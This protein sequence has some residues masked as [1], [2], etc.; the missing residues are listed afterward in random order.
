MHCSKYCIFMGFLVV[1]TWLPLRFVCP[2]ACLCWEG[3]VAD[4]TVATGYETRLGPCLSKHA[5]SVTCNTDPSGQEI[6]DRKETQEL[7]DKGT[8]GQRGREVGGNETPE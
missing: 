8:T 6:A 1:T 3:G 2:C 7:I 4:G 5:A